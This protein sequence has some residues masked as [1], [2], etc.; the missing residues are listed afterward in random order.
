MDDFG[1]PNSPVPRTQ[2]VTLVVA[3]LLAVHHLLFRDEVAGG[4]EEVQHLVDPVRPL[5]QVLLLVAVLREADGAVHPVDLRAA[6]QALPHGR[7]ICRPAFLCL[8]SC[9]K[10]L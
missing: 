9:G 8:F 5:V 6:E 2:R 1:A 10:P 7:C 3:A 4:A